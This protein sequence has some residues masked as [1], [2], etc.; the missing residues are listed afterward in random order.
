MSP[1]KASQTSSASDHSP[2][3]RL[4]PD[5]APTSRAVSEQILT[6]RKEKRNQLSKPKSS[7][8]NVTADKALPWK[9]AC[10]QER[11]SAPGCAR[12]AGGFGQCWAGHFFQGGL[13]ASGSLSCRVTSRAMESVQDQ[14]SLFST[15]IGTTDALE[16]VAEKNEKGVFTPPE[17]LP[18]VLEG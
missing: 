15:G 7:S 8:S 14:K 17:S 11:V 10:C 16:A 6:N 5:M 2:A 9:S 18:L 12:A 1:A 4:Q 13:K 3:A